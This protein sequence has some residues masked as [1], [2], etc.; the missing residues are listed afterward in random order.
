MTVSVVIPCYNVERYV[1]EC[2]TSVLQQT[3][4]NMEIIC[5][6]DGSSDETVSKIKKLQE[7]HNDKIHLIETPNRGASSA[8]NSGLR[9]A[10]G[11][12]IQFLDADDILLPGKINHQIKL[13][14]DSNSVPSF[15]VGDYIR[16]DYNGYETKIRADRRSPWYG[17]IGIRLG[18]TS[19][20]LWN[21]KIIAGIGGWDEKLKS[22]QEYDLMFRILQFRPDVIY[23]GEFN[24]VFRR[25]E[26][27]SIS[28][29]NF[30]ENRTIAIHLRQRIYD[31]LYSK[32]LFTGELKEH[33][34]Q[35][36]FTEIRALFSYDREEAKRM[37]DR[38]FPADFKL[39]D[40]TLYNKS[41]MT[42]FGLFGFEYS[43][44]IWNNYTN[45]RNKLKNYFLFN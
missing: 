37:Y 9:F 27:G 22:S 15:V 19:S 20:N 24:T 23:D 25:R 45:F 43:Q 41:Y 17:L 13:I 31:Y 38:M 40:R 1:E 36:L 44:I 2:I 21:K 18:R 10:G 3:Y 11:E 14:K 28:R 39:T 30:R 12:F 5:V 26:T 6:D 16:R 7:K 8:R 35:L 4:S 32:G 42:L 29:T 33:Y 34:Y